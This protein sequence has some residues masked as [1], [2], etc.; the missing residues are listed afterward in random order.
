MA[1]SAYLL[2]SHKHSVTA[3]LY[4]LPPHRI[5]QVRPLSPRHVIHHLLDCI[6]LRSGPL[7]LQ[8]TVDVYCNLYLH[9]CLLAALPRCQHAGSLLLAAFLTA[10]RP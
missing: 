8:L 4:F 9:K 1:P 10:F 5:K 7:G 2:G 6:V 3:C